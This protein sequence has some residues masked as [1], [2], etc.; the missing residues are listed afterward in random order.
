MAVVPPIPLHPMVYICQLTVKRVDRQAV[1]VPN[2][3]SGQVNVVGTKS[4]DAVWRS[5]CNPAPV[6]YFT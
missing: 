1:A 4:W 5:R 6:P 3:F 2:P